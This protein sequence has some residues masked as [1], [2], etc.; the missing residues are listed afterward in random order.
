M[1][2]R[3]VSVTITWYGLVIGWARDFTD[4]DLLVS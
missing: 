3:N 2:F 4:F 1:K